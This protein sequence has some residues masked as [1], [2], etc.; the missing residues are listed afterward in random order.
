M[1]TFATKKLSTGANGQ[2]E[3][4]AASFVRAGLIEHGS[5]L[6]TGRLAAHAAQRLALSGSATRDSGCGH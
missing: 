6:V 4:A 5:V 1:P 2:K 3:D